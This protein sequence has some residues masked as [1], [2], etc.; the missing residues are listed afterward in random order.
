MP[1]RTTYLSYKQDQK[2][3][4]YWITRACKDII[5][6]SP[7]EAPPILT[8]ASRRAATLTVIGSTLLQK[9]LK[10]DARDED[11]EEAIFSNKF[12]LP[13][14]DGQSTSNNDEDETPQDTKQS[15][16]ANIAP[17]LKK[18]PINKGKRRTRGRKVKT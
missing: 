8:P 9:N 12:S 6:T 7:S 1:D 4:V 5:N 18:K 10:S 3:L 17:Q 13:S 16:P 11:K 2:L 14:L 15:P